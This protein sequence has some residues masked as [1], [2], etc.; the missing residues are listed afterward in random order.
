[1]PKITCN[2]CGKYVPIRKGAAWGGCPKRLLDGKP[3][4][5]RKSDESCGDFHY[6][7]VSQQQ[8]A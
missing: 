3:V 5:V 2:D 1:M 4:V 6:Y 7:G 8:E